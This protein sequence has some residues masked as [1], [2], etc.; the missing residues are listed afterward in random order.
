MGQARPRAA[1]APDDIDFSDLDF[2]TRPL[3]ERDAAFALLRERPEAPFYAETMDVGGGVGPGYYVLT[4]HADVQEASR[5]PEV[6]SS[7]QGIRIEERAPEF[8]EIFNSM[9][10]MDDPRHARLR[11]IVSQAFTPRMIQRFAG[12]VE[13]AAAEVV[14]R[15]AERGSCDFVAEIAAR[16]P[17]RIICD[18]M[19]IDEKDQAFVFD[20]SNVILGAEDPEYVAELE[21]VSTAV[22][23]AANELGD[24]VAD[25][26]RVRAERPAGDLT[27]ALISAN[28]DGERL[29]RQEIASF[30][31]LLVLAGN[32]TT[33]N[34]ISHGLVLLTDHPEQRAR[35]ASDFDGYA[36]TAVEE[37]VRVASPVVYMRRTLTRDHETASGQRF[38]EGDKVLLCYWS[39]NRDESVF[40]A[41]D[42]FDVGRD[43]NPHIGFGAAGPHFCLG[44][45]LARREITVMFR[46]L[47][48]RVPDIRASGEPDRLR[49]SFLNGIKRLP[50]EFTPVR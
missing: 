19:G 36:R 7:A 18:L 38:A 41:P 24:L 9:I 40:D 34:A 3:D 37:I 2:W 12:D 25:L 43:P 16:L 13:R 15:V 22:M 45:H 21:D 50:C 47:F 48:R 8:V 46:E 1:L 11:R 29:T 20:R 35:W 32:E 33:R 5:H 28:P 23:A 4:R 6:F 39:A 44:A 30:F 17:L 10:S 31:V 42:R 27:T 14:D 26:A 49:S